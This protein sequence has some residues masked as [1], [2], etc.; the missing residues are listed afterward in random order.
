MPELIENYAMIFHR[1]VIYTRYFCGAAFIAVFLFY[2]II[3]KNLPDSTA[4][5][6]RDVKEI[7]NTG[8]S[9]KFNGEMTREN[10][11]ERISIIIREFEDFD[12][13]LSKTVDSV[14]T[15]LGKVPVF[16]VADHLPY[17]PLML[18]N[19]EGVKV[20]TLSSDLTK[21]YSTSCPLHF[22][23]SQ[24]VFIIPDGVKIRDWK[25]VHDYVTFLHS[26]QDTRAVAVP[27]AN[28]RL[29][30]EGLN[31]DLKRWSVSFQG[32]YSE[33]TFYCPFL[34]GSHGLLME[35]DTFKSLSEPF[36]RP[37]PFT[38]YVQA[39]LKDWKVRLMKSWGL[40]VLKDLYQDPHSKWKHKRAEVERLK[41]FYQ[42]VGIKQ[43]ILTNGLTQFYGC[44]KDTSRCF[45]TVV[46]DMPDYLYLGRWTPPCCLNALRQTARHVFLVLEKCQVRYWLEGGSLLGAAR[47]SDI[48]PWDYD[49]DIG[50]YKE[51]VDRCS[52]LTKARQEKYIDDKEFVWEKAV[53]G[54]F[55]R[56]QYSDTNHLHVDI[57][58]FYSRNGTMT[59]DT[60]FQTHRQDT[61]FPERFLQPLTKI[62]FVGVLAGAPNNV[63]EFLE[64][65]F[66]EGVIENPKYPN[67]QKPS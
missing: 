13:S 6:G 25:Q 1:K 9:G 28:A 14:Q 59:K 31:V 47:H 39:K 30:C 26:K 33:E 20:V 49:V 4:R 10:L 43:E 22:F 15:T 38:F 52:S 65:K 45:G 48:I 16:I 63:R 36:A 7:S 61:E 42:G 46:N 17:P 3:F 11:A 58:P 24:Y 64:F 66:G 8:Q 23:R 55:F 40:D 12:N 51:D 2:L 62:E 27:V 5:A 57:Y 53:E 34:R 54:D 37:F 21:N 60:W 56:V 44:G 29:E 35:T 18:E 50:I 32:N 19:K 67:L 41:S